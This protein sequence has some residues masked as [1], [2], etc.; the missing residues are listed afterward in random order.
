MLAQTVRNNLTNTKEI[1][2]RSKAAKFSSMFQT[3]SNTNIKNPGLV[4]ILTKAGLKSVSEQDPLLGKI[5]MRGNI[6]IADAKSQY[7]EIS[8]YIVEN[9]NEAVVK[10]PLKPSVVSGE[11]LP[12]FKSISTKLSSMEIQTSELQPQSI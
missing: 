10:L 7:N 2:L 1:K 3:S 6:E 8:D 12:F 4:Q 5:P 9:P 11:K